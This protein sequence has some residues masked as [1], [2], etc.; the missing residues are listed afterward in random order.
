MTEPYRI[1]L[2]DR[3]LDA[4]PRLKAELELATGGQ[5]MV[6]DPHYLLATVAKLEPD[7]MVAAASSV[8]LIPAVRDERPGIPVV[9][10][11]STP[12]LDDAV[13]AVRHGATDFLTEV[14]PAAVLAIRLIELADAYRSGA[15]GARRR[16]TVLAIGAHPDD[17][18]T[19]VGGILAAHR[20][21]GD[22]LTIL[23]LSQ[24]RREGGME[25]AWAEGSASAAI[26]GARLV[27]EDHL[28]NGFQGVLAAITAVVEAVEPSIVYT[29]SGND[30][31][32]D[33][34]VVHEAAV[35]ACEEVPTVACYHGTTG[36]IEFAPTRFVPI[37]GF[38]ESKLAMLACFAT[39]G[40]RPE[41][42]SPDFALASARYW[43]QYGQ[44]SFCEP[45]EIIRESLLSPVAP[46]LAPTAGHARDTDA[47]EI[48]A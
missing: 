16:Q 26:V 45:L 19:G 22:E 42:L 37:D 23:T 28:H 18:E 24:G 4:L 32:Q 47:I 1:L 7:V 6:T 44:G 8:E 21:L 10:M 27:L 48:S 33:H 12:T 41:Y 38:T 31:R 13:R 5:V 36:T 35:A 29:H 11:T 17:V 3:D 34:R 30:R 20:A 2:I 43:S 9:I 39:R 25:V 14:P 15:A 46:A 40:E